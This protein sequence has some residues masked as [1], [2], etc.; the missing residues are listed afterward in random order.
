MSEDRTRL[1]WLSPQARTP[2]QFRDAEIRQ[3]LRTAKDSGYRVVL[4]LLS[5]RHPKLTDLLLSN[6][7]VDWLFHCYDLN[8]K[9]RCLDIGSEW[10]SLAFPLAKFFDVVVSF[11]IEPVKLA[12]QQIRATQDEATN[13][14]PIRG[15]LLSLPFSDDRFDLI[16]ANGALEWVTL[17]CRDNARSV[18][19]QFLKEVRRCLTSDGCLFFGIKNKFGLPFW[20]GTQERASL[21]FTSILARGIA[22]VPTSKLLRQEAWTSSRTYNHS[23][24]GY[25]ALLREAGFRETE[26]YWTYPS[27]KW[28]KFAGRLDDGSGY[29][30][31][32]KYHWT[33]YP[34]MAFQKKLASLVMMSTPLAIVGKLCQLL[35]PGFLI[36]AWKES[37]STTVE[38][39]IAQAVRG[40]SLVR[41]SG[42]DSPCSKISWVGLD[43][44][45]MRSF[46]RMSR[47]F[48]SKQVEREERLQKIHAGISYLEHASRGLFFFTE[49]PLKARPC[50][51]R[52]TEDARRAIDW[53]VQFQHATALGPIREPE[54]EREE[55]DIK[56]ALC[57]FESGTSA[58]KETLGQIEDLARFL[59][60]AGTPNCAEHG[61]FAPNNIFLSRKGAVLVID[62]EFYRPSGNPMFDPCFFVV[63]ISSRPVLDTSFRRNLMGQGPYSSVVSSWAQRFCAERKLP[64]KAFLL[65]IPYVLCRCVERCSIYSKAPSPQVYEYL[66]LLELW[67]SE[68][69]HSDFSWMIRS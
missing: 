18:Q 10:G 37:K 41:M 52:R 13:V 32:A 67:N 14:L 56:V 48:E 68:I 9:S 44:R 23:F 12:F 46:S 34:D 21:P 60:S 27:C 25:K 35:W 57:R 3:L 47:C 65:G 62:W 66:R 55:E 15:D 2:A 8:H 69:R 19:L 17:A 22:D 40:R 50:A 51:L 61:D 53:L 26:F 5:R 59:V 33:N 4:D 36:F 54:T 63:S 45:E 16:A 42:R 30:F 58:L 43:N 38:D 28:P 6:I 24:R 31:L 7:R 64:I 11:E 39:A 49:E 1:P 20:F 29:A